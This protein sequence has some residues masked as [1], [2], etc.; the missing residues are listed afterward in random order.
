MSW[1]SRHA[2]LARTVNRVVGG[3][4]VTW[5]TVSGSGIFE[6]NSELVLGDQVISMDYA[7]H[8]LPTALFGSL[9]Y[10]DTVTVNGVIYVVR[11]APMPIGDGLYCVVALSKPDPPPAPAP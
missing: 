2:L 3:V 1:A 6:Q 4:S 8:N 11:H 9:S 10:G 5:G 7:L